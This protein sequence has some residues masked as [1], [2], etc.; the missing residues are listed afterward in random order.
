MV[1]ESRAYDRL[2]LFVVHYRQT[3]CHLLRSPILSF[4]PTLISF[5]H[6][7]S[8]L[9]IWVIPP[10]RDRFISLMSSEAHLGLKIPTYI[11]RINHETGTCH[12]YINFRYRNKQILTRTLI[13]NAMSTSHLDLVD[14]TSLAPFTHLPWPSQLNVIF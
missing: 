4:D 14:L 8:I 2:S 10:L 12:R 13:S 3:Y 1:R 11:H 7:A 5:C 6:L 9:G